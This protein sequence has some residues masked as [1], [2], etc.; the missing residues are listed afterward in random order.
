MD[1]SDSPLEWKKLDGHRA[2]LD[3]LDGIIDKAHTANPNYKV[4]RSQWRAVRNLSNRYLGTSAGDHVFDKDP[5]TLRS[6]IFEVRGLIQDRMHELEYSHR[7][8][9]HDQQ[10][11]KARRPNQ[12]SLAIDG[13]KVRELREGV[14]QPVF[15][16]RLGI[17]VDTLQRAEAGRA[18]PKTLKAILK[19][20]S[21]K[22][23]NLKRQDLVIN[24]PQ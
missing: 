12:L 10:Q 16:R 22:D 4:R 19:S 23:K 3:Q 7:A 2:T 13:E 17:S 20:K 11:A 6:L 5:S 24:P 8:G 15:V 9:H 14:S 1:H 18:T 21:A